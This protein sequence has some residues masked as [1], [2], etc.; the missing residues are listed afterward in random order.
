MRE[1]HAPPINRLYDCLLIETYDLIGVVADYSRIA[2][3]FE[4]GRWLNASGRSNSASLNMSD[5]DETS[6]KTRLI[7]RIGQ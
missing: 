2:P 4:I 6:G 7:G 1:D 5:Y 3:T